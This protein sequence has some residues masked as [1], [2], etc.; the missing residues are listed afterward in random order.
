MTKLNRVTIEQ[1]IN[2]SSDGD[3][4]YISVKVTPTLRNE[5]KVLIVK[6]QSETYIGVEM[7]HFGIILYHSFTIGTPSHETSSTGGGD[8]KAKGYGLVKYSMKFRCRIQQSLM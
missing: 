6:S 7:N 3:S 8:P 2:R 1:K 5:N 4:K